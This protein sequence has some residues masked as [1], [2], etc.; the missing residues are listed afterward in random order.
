MTILAELYL[1]HTASA[2]FPEKDPINT[3]P[4]S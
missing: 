2:D 4:T 1:I 3:Y